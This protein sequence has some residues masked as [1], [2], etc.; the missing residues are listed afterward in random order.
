MTKEELLE[1]LNVVGD[2]IP[3]RQGLDDGW[4]AISNSTVYFIGQRLGKWSVIQE[5]LRSTI[6]NVEV[7]DGFLGKEMNL[8]CNG[9]RI[10]FKKVPVDVDI[11]AFMGGEGVATAK[12]SASTVPSDSMDTLRKEEPKNRP[13]LTVEESSENVSSLHSFES[14]TEESTS[15]QGNPSSL[16]ENFDIEG[17]LFTQDQL[18]VE[19]SNVQQRS[20]PIPPGESQQ[21]RGIPPEIEENEVSG[22]FGKLFTW[23]IFFMVC[24]GFFG[25]C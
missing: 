12:P 7:K 18:T 19:P 17:D 9:R 6:N 23:I 10:T 4:L 3:L 21:R 13:S 5:W 8:H 14:L 25:D 22:K 1:S 24:S 15:D 16:F 2:S 20:K 11:A